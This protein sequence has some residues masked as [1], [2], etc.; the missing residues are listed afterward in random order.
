MKFKQEGDWFIST[1]MLIG[2][3]DDVWK[4]Q[5]C[6]HEAYHERGK[7]VDKGMLIVQEVCNGCVASR[8]K[9]RPATAEEID[10]KKG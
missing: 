4:A 9:Y 3:S 7:K 8:V 1:P 6:A 2:S 5:K 10:G